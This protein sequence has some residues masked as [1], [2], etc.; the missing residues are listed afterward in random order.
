M[1]HEEEY[2]PKESKKIRMR[3]RTEKETRNRKKLHEE[4]LRY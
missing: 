1:M 3:N 2:K 4:Y